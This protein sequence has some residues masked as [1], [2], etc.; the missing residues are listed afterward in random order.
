MAKAKKAAPNAV[1]TVDVQDGDAC[2]V[3]AGSHTGESGRVENSSVSKTGHV[4]IIV[5]QAN[6]ARFK[7]P[8]RNVIL[9][10]RRAR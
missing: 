7:T 3:V 6:G 4:A 9:R 5:R 1:E 10:R 8:A 2:E